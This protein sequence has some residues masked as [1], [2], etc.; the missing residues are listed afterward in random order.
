MQLISLHY[1]KTAI[2]WH[3]NIICYLLMADTS[4]KSPCDDT[5]YLLT[6]LYTVAYWYYIITCCLLRADICLK[7][8]CDK[9]EITNWHY[10]N[11]LLTGTNLYIFIYWHY[12]MACYLLMADIYICVIKKTYVR[13]LKLLTGTTEMKL[14]M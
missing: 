6:L 13:N 1:S 7:S 4:I 5:C 8:L 11:V 2:Y 3:Y 10:I 12:I 9:L 14:Y